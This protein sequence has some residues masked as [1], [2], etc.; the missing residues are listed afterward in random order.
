MA[1]A[2]FVSRG[3]AFVVD[4]MISGVVSTVGYALIRAG[5]QAL[6]YDMSGGGRVATGFLSS[7]PLVF[8]AYCAIFWSLSGRTP[9]MAL[10]GLRV[11]RPD[12]TTPSLVRAV[13]RVAGYAVSAVLMLG[14]AWILVDRRRQGFHD[15][16]AGTFVVYSEVPT[17][18][19]AMR[20]RREAR[21]AAVIDRSG[22]V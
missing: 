7:L 20:R 14:F 22:T 16:L 8:V 15:K 13:G 3:I 1:Y 18:S 11:V 21:R 4:G 19:S 9:G 5:G 6:G 10:M 17:M 12:G 2:G